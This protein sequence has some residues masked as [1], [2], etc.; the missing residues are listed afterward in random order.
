[1]TGDAHVRFPHLVVHFVKWSYGN[2]LDGV[3][4]PQRGC[5]IEHLIDLVASAQNSELDRDFP[6]EPSDCFDA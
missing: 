6:L 2:E 1:M 4:D 3:P 5:Q